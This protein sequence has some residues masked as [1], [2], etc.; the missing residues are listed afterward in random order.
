MLVVDDYT[1]ELLEEVMNVN[2]ILNLNVT[3]QSISIRPLAPFMIADRA[4]TR[5]ETTQSSRESR[6]LSTVF[7]LV[8]ISRW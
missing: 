4:G 1:R 3:G 7:L 2:E 6:R 8:Q 5:R